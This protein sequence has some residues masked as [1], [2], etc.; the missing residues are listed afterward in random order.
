MCRKLGLIYEKIKFSIVIENKN[1][2][3][4]SS[5]IVSHEIIEIVRNSYRRYFYAEKFFF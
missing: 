1:N 3:K 4:N 5:S 2:I